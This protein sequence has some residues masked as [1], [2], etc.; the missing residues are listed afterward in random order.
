MT[1]QIRNQ[2]DLGTER[3]PS[4]F[5]HAV[6]V[7]WHFCVWCRLV[8]LDALLLNYYS[9]YFKIG[10]RQLS[11]GREKE[12]PNRGVRRRLF[13]VRQSHRLSSSLFLRR[14]RHFWTRLTWPRCR[15]HLYFHNSGISQSKL[16][17]IPFLARLQEWKHFKWI[18]YHSEGLF[19]YLSYMKLWLISTL[20]RPK[21]PTTK[22]LHN[23]T[24]PMVVCIGIFRSPSKCSIVSLRLSRV[25]FFTDSIQ[26]VPPPPLPL[27]SPPPPPP[28]AVVIQD[29]FG[30][31]RGEAG[32]V[33]V[34]SLGR[35]RVELSLYLEY[36]K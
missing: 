2:F 21:L 34:G 23:G 25:W 27:P 22:Q 20:A 17:W 15:S 32:C 35:A 33:V 29:A 7:W 3:P 10:S 1:K 30:E 26:P 8:H 4:G 36:G 5:A 19:I 16:R 9:L 18:E 24:F 12:F 14:R 11:I 13:V 31:R 6:Q 28:R